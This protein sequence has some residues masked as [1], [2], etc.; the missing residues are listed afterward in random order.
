MKI[1]KRPFKTVMKCIK[2]LG[3]S[4]KR[5]SRPLWKRL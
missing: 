1:Y 2:E 5:C 3:K 4:N